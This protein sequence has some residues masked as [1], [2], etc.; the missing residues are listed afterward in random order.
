MSL[1][2]MLK[3]LEEIKALPKTRPGTYLHMGCGPQILEG[4]INIDGYYEHPQVM[5][6]DIG[7]K[8]PFEPNSVQGIYS[9]HS[10]E[11]LPIRKAYKALHFWV[12]ML[13]PGGKLYLAVPDLNE[14]CRI[15]IDPNVP[16]DLKWDWYIYTL[17]G[18]QRNSAISTADKSLDHELDH[19]QFHTTGFTIPLLKRILEGQHR[20]K[21][22][23]A[24]VYDGWGTPS[25]FLIAEKPL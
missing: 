10:L 5:K 14:I 22:N 8:L 9:S 18:Y 7:E 21:I 25:I 17:F 3:H 24:F 4:F 20:M 23:D 16:E 19:G 1:D 2:K 11:H 15:M 12:E 13:A 6:G